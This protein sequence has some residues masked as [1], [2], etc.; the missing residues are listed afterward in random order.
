MR[1]LVVRQLKRLRNAPVPPAALLSGRAR[2]V[3]AMRLE[4]MRPRP[5][6]VFAWRPVLA[7]L[8]GFAVLTGGGTVMA[9]HGSVPGDALYRVKIAAEG[10]RLRL[11]MSDDAR[12]RFRAVQAGRRLEEA[13][14]VMVRADLAQEEREGRIADAMGRYEEHV[15]AM[16]ALAL[17]AG[18]EPKAIPARTRAMAAV[19]RVLERQEA[20]VAS[21]SASAGTLKAL[22][23]DRVPGALELHADVLVSAESDDEDDD[24]R[25]EALEERFRQR[26]E[27]LRALL[28][29]RG[30]RHEDAREGRREPTEERLERDDDRLES[31]EERQDA[32]S[33]SGGEES[34]PELL[35]IESDADVD[36]S[37]RL[38]FRALTE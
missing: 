14:E 36:A 24:D 6:A 8:V 28:E 23:I 20:L 1:W 31:L 25:D 9:A 21:A 4:P 33:A 16:A 5:T 18:V 26:G 30:R 3:E 34:L 32:E 38:R 10:A 17:R 15:V 35:R 37:L 2:L 27:R 12:F 7:G 29:K 11:A 13:A 19:D 22:V